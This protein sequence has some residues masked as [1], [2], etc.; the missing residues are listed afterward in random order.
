M[1]IEVEEEEA[2]KEKEI[3]AQELKI[4]EFKKT[5]KKSTTPS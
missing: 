5:V 1:P 4:L 3:N 2:N